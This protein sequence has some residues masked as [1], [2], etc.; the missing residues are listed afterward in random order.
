MKF[1]LFLIFMSSTTLFACCSY[2]FH[3]I[4]RVL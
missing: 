4:T 3:F 2:S 1:K